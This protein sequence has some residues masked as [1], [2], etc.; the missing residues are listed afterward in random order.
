MIKRN[1]KQLSVYKIE[2]DI[3]NLPLLCLRNL[4]LEGISDDIYITRKNRFYGGICLDDIVN[5]GQN[6]WV[7]INK[8]IIVL[9]G[10][11]VI[12]AHE[13]FQRKK[14]IHAIPVINEQNELVGEYSRWDDEQYIRRNRKLLE[15]CSDCAKKFFEAYEAVYVVE[16]NTSDVYQ[17]MIEYFNSNGIVYTVLCEEQVEKKLEENAICIFHSEDEKRKVQCLCQIDIQTCTDMQWKLDMETCKSMMTQIMEDIQLERLNITKPADCSFRMLNVKATILLS[18]LQKKGISCF[19]FYEDEKEYTE[20]GKIFKAE[21]RKRLEQHP[22][23]LRK[24]WTKKDEND[25]F[26]GELY[27]VED[28]ENNIAQ[29]IIFNAF[30]DYQYKGKI[31]SKYVNADGRRI[32]CFQPDKYIGKIYCLGPCSIMG[33]HVEDQYTIPSC[34]QK[35]LLENGYM[36]RVENYGDMIRPDAA[37][38]D[39]LEEINSYYA[40]DIVIYMPYHSRTVGISGCS[41]EEIFEEYQIP[42]TWVKDVNYGHANHKANDLVADGILE[43]IKTQL[44][45]ETAV[46][47][48]GIAVHIDVQDIVADF[49]KKNIWINIFGD[50]AE[51]NILQ[52]EQLLWKA[53]FLQ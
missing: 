37:I 11:N 3:E 46:G 13:I 53:I 51:T 21:V 47:N 7:K 28:Y 27:G 17:W 19:V 2:D 41:M 15:V 8:D 45:K 34:L 35:K 9:A 36:Y 25:E 31:S 39:K 29:E 38:D 52:S 1:S 22:L 33:G 42:S 32:T 49:V 16:Q 48:N 5:H 6:A 43:R 24:P 30:N 20:Y 50:F 44:K 12:R 14:Q 40:E 26:Y 23:N 18:M 10:Y 4:Y